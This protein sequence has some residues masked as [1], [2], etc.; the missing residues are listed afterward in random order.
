MKN[1]QKAALYDQGWNEIEKWENFYV[2]KFY[3][4]EPTCAANNLSFSAVGLVIFRN[5]LMRTSN[6]LGAYK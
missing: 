2:L 4:W 6:K 1:L 5:M 3:M